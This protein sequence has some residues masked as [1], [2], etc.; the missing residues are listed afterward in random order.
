MRR[1]EN[2]LIHIPRVNLARA[3][4][5]DRLAIT[6]SR[7]IKFRLTKCLAIM[8]IISSSKSCPGSEIRTMGTGVR[9]IE[10]D[11]VEACALVD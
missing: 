1:D 5:G 7:E 4:D 8:S 3:K 2:T 9:H 11:D 10:V 6:P